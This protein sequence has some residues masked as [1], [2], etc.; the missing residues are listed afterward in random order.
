MTR[1][2]SSG[3]RERRRR[4]AARAALPSPRRRSAARAARGA[5]RPEAG[6]RLVRGR[7]LALSR[8]SSTG[9]AAPS[10]PTPS[11]SASCAPT[12]TTASTATTPVKHRVL[13]DRLL[14]QARG[15]DGGGAPGRLRRRRALSGS[16]GRRALIPDFDAVWASP[17]A[18]TKLL[19]LARSVEREPSLLGL[20][21]HMLAVARADAGTAGPAAV[22]NRSA[23]PAPPRKKQEA[24]M[25]GFFLSLGVHAAGVSAPGGAGVVD[26][27]AAAGAEAA[28][29]CAATISD[30]RGDREAAAGAAAGA[31]REGTPPRLRPVCRRRRHR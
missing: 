30:D 27:R 16:K 20:S 23:R 22:S 14:P 2:S 19:D 11:S 3:R 25:R 6:R 17:A 21:S 10:S 12:S 13:H 15:A 18:R 8:R 1:G 5:P 24:I 9:C 7:D 29:Q 26:Q 31:V 28:R 4:A